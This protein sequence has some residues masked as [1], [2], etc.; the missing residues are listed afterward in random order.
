MQDTSRDVAG[1]PAV[2]D[3]GYLPQSTQSECGRDILLANTERA[4]KSFDSAISGLWWWQQ[5]M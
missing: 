4:G 5:S 1:Q 2:A 3:Q